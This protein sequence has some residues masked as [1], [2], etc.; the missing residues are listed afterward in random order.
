MN[1]RN[2]WIFA[3][4]QV[5]LLAG[6]AIGGTPVPAGDVERARAILNE[7]NNL[8]HPEALA[9]LAELHPD[10]VIPALVGYIDSHVRVSILPEQVIAIEMLRKMDGV[11]DYFRKQIDAIRKRPGAVFALE[12]VFEKLGAI[13]SEDA[14]KAAALYLFDETPAMRL[15][16][17][18]DIDISIA[19]S[20]KSQSVSVL[21]QMNLPNAPLT[22]KDHKSRDE[23]IRI[24]RKWAIEN[25]YVTEEQRATVEPRMPDPGDARR[26][27]PKPR[28]A[29]QPGSNDPSSPSDHM[30]PGSIANIS[31]APEASGR[32]LYVW[33]GISIAALFS[34]A[35]LL[36]RFRKMNGNSRR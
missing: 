23:E 7:V 17:A 18:G 16:K 8:G 25:K 27:G 21:M 26:T 19:D 6:L 34:G 29:A 24:W 33:L 4:F 1:A 22:D 30:T 13:S 12:P 14:A 5:I 32:S 20:I 11:G 36:L 35:W 28:S 31:K 3:V 10:V 15:G 9:R 2:C